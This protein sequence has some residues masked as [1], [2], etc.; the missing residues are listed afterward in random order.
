MDD[1]VAN[2]LSNWVDANILNASR[3]PDD[4]GTLKAHYL[5]DAVAAGIPLDDVNDS[6]PQAKQ[7]IAKARRA[8]LNPGK[9]E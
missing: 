1:R 9:R 2:F 8:E 4:V 5:T 3:E 7:A 6:W